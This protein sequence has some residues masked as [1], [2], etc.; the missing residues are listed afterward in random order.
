MASLLDIKAVS[1]RIS[2]SPSWI[3]EKVNLNLFPR[4]TVK[5]GKTLWREEVIDAWI[6]AEVPLKSKDAS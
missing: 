4:G 5:H 1:K 3:R 2:F 6:E